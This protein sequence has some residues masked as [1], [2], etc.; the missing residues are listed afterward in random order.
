VTRI[1]QLGPV[2]MDP[3]KEYPKELTHGDDDVVVPSVDSKLSP[4]E[5]A[6][7]QMRYRLVGNPKHADRV[8][9]LCNL[10]NEWPENF[11][12]HI[13]VNWESGKKITL[14][15]QDVQKVTVPVLTIHG[16]YDRNAPYGSGREWAMTLPNARLVTVPHAAHQSWSDAPEIVFAAI[17]EFL[18]GE[19]PRAAEKPR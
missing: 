15:P 12:R 16:T 11:R 9:S 8:T 6:D 2:S 7:A 18:R 17:R 4:C 19:W 10:P 13:A 14:T 1:V 3:T 5:I